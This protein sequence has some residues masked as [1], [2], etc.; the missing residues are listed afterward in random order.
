METKKTH[1]EELYPPLPDELIHQILLRL[2]VKSLLR[3]KC[4]CKSWFSLISDPH[5]ANS[6]FQITAPTH[7]RRLLFISESNPI[8]R[9]INFDAS[10]HD[11]DSIIS[12]S[13]NF[14]RLPLKY[15]SEEQIHV[16]KGS[17]R[18]IVVLRSSLGFHLWNP[19][20]GIHK[21][22][23]L[24]PNDN[25][26]N[27]FG[28]GYDQSTDDYLVISISK[29]TYCH[30]LYL[31]FFSLRAN[32]WKQI[33]TEYRY[34]NPP[35]PQ[36]DGVGLLFNGAIHWFG[37]R[38]DND[39][40]ETVIVVFDLT[41]RKLSYI[42]FPHDFDPAGNDRGLWVFG[43][44]LS[45]WSVDDDYDTV[46]IWVMKEYKLHSSW[47]KTIVLPIVEDH[48]CC[49]PLC[50]T[51]S[52]DIVRTNSIRT[53][54]DKY[55][56]KGQL[57]EYRPYCDLPDWDPYQKALY[58]ES[59]ISFCDNKMTEPRRLRLIFSFTIFIFIIILYHA[60]FKWQ[61]LYL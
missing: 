8:T 31:Y 58:V 17:C 21:K 49:V 41:E 18:G 47:T 19:S 40:E 14:Y 20:T 45:I 48:E 54:L 61:H 29:A 22:I 3:F 33:E 55:D 37:F 24:S 28:F 27:L 50:S 9:S 6:H 42:H 60:L 30:P 35:E 2:P 16:I 11:D 34:Y 26:A 12:L 4:V 38:K 53:R 52:G 36:G 13:H 5:F 46:D 51:K 56:D 39:L 57:L 32:T 7:T 59:L 23:P 1:E 44:F 43:E 10:L 15:S 25:Y